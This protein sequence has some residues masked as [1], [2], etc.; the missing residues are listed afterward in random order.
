MRLS[1]PALDRQR[2]AEDWAPGVQVGRCRKLGCTSPHCATSM[3]E[4]DGMPWTFAHPAAAVLVRR[5][6]GASLPLSGLAMGSLSPDFGY[7]VGVMTQ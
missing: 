7:Y 4:F 3:E 6:G 2:G 5:F 1:R